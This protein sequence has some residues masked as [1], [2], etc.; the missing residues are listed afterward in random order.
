MQLMLAFG[1]I[2]KF[3][4]KNRQSIGK[5]KGGPKRTAPHKYNSCNFVSSN[6]QSERPKVYFSLLMFCDMP[7]GTKG[8]IIKSTK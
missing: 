4:K 1:A 3:L 8:Y 2:F 7:S 6:P 5:T